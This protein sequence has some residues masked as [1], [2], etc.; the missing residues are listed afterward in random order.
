MAIKM[1]SLRK[2]LWKVRC[3]YQMHSLVPPAFWVGF[4]FANGAFWAIVVIDLISDLAR[5][6]R[7][8]LGFDI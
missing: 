3:Y 6:T 7:G 4:W 2:A 8:L 1:T 5:F